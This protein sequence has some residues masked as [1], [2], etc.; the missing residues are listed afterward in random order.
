MLAGEQGGDEQDGGG[1]GGDSTDLDAAGEVAPADQ[2]VAEESTGDNAE[3]R[4]G[5][6]H[7][8]QQIGHHLADPVLLAREFE[9]ERLH[10]CQEVMRA[11]AGGDQHEVGTHAD[12]VPG[13][14]DQRKTADVAVQDEPWIRNDPTFTSELLDVGGRDAFG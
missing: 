10:A 3:Y 11:R 6:D 9:P 7:Q 2:R 5:S 1:G 8:Q 12:D 14:G 13:C 4:P